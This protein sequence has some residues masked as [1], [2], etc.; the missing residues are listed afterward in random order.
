M[1]K[2][3]IELRTGGQVWETLQIE[4]EDHTA[5]R[6]EL[7][8]F[9]GELLKDHADKIWEDEDWRVDVTDER[10]MILYILH[11]SVTDSPATHPLRR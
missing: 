11:V 3:H 4:G 5:V 2:Y 10:G 6:I 1:A 8:Q 7:A 9:V